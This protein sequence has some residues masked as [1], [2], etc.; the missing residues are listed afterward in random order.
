MWEC[1][2]YIAEF[3]LS[4]GNK[5][6][7]KCLELLNLMLS[8]M[9]KKWKIN[10]SAFYRH[11]IEKTDNDNI[12]EQMLPGIIHDLE[13]DE[14]LNFLRSKSKVSRNNKSLERKL[15]LTLTI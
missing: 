12:G 7:E 8:S 11:M 9:K 4:V 13:N 3:Q 15:I 10:S 6:A 14:K 2:S 5:D 1:T